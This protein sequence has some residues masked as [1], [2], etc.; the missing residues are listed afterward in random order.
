MLNRQQIKA[1][2]MEVLGAHPQGIGGPKLSA[3]L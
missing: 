1:K 3:R 2:A